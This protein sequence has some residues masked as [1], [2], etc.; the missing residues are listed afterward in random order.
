[1]RGKLRDKRADTKR[2]S[3]KRE[4]VVRRRPVRRDNR[5]L[6]WLG[7]QLREKEDEK[8]DDEGDLLLEQTQK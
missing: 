2:D 4:L 8:F 1:M 6:T 7:E 5:N 3:F